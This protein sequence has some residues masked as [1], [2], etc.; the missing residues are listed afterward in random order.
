MDSFGDPLWRFARVFDF[1]FELIKLPLFCGNDPKFV[2]FREGEEN[3]F[4][5]GGEYVDSSNDHHVV[6]ST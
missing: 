5:T 3:C 4:E 6:D 2:H 1:D